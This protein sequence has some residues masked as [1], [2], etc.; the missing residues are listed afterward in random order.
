[1]PHRVGRPVEGGDD[2]GA[3]L[4]QAR[5]AALALQGLQVR[6]GEV[7][8]VVIGPLAVRHVLQHDLHPVHH[9]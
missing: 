6:R 5:L 9:I 8:D 2:G 3:E 1:M 4:V 7:V